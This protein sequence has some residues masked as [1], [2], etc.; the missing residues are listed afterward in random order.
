[1]AKAWIHYDHNANSVLA[2]YGISGVT[3]TS[4]GLFTVAFDVDFSS[5]NYAIAG[6]NREN[7]ATNEATGLG[8]QYNHAP[9]AGS[10][11]LL[12]FRI[13]GT[14]IDSPDIGVTFHGVSA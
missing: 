9:A 3:D 8:I 2:E 5:D 7:G 1:M 14:R 6:I 13:D 11:P 12:S 10:V 4:A